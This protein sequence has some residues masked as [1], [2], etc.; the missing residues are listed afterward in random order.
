MNLGMN[1][2]PPSYKTSCREREIPEAI[3][4]VLVPHLRM[5]RREASLPAIRVFYVI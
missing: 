3:A 5:V 2:H 1:D 4:L